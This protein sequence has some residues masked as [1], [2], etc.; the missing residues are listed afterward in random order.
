MTDD[1]AVAA[2]L[3]AVR[4]ADE[5]IERAN[6]EAHEIQRVAGDLRAQAIARLVDVAGRA[7]AAEAL[8]VSLKAVDKATARARALGSA[9]P[10]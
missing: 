5:G 1:V 6:E 3:A 7:G 4:E 10:R 2:A 9:P 8:G